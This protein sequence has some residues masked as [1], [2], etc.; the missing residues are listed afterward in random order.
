MLNS[1]VR[2]PPLRCTDASAAT[3]S[4]ELNAAERCAPLHS[5]EISKA[6]VQHYYQMFDTN[7]PALQS[8]YQEGSMLSFESEQFMGIQA[9]MTKLTTLK[10]NTVQHQAS[11]SPGIEP[12]S[13]RSSSH[14]SSL[15]AACGARGL[16]VLWPVASL[17]LG[18]SC[19]SDFPG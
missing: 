12:T 18:W 13:P 2:I 7:R 5:P 3:P 1:Q 8:L 4:L 14:R 11:A 10:F 17:W 15:L 6:F 9:I 19:P 16:A